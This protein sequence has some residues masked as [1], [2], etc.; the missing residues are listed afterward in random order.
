MEFDD[1]EFDFNGFHNM[2]DLGEPTSVEKFTQGGVTYELKVWQ[3]A[4]GV[5][6]TMDIIDV[7]SNF[8]DIDF[9]VVK[10]EVSFNKD[11]L[12]SVFDNAGAIPMGFLRLLGEAAQLHDSHAERFRG[13]KP[14]EL[15][16]EEQIEELE[17]DLLVVVGQEDYEAAGDIKKEIET[18]KLKTNG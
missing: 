4:N 9:K 13:M 5:I 8:D 7:S 14:P 10:E 3:T 16:I 18:L 15:T 12:N 11:D 1:N 6:K 17:E 2:K